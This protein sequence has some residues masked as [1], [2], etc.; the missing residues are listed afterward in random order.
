MT[1]GSDFSH[2]I[3]LLLILLI[4]LILLIFSQSFSK[5]ARD[6]GEC[7]VVQ[8]NHGS[9]RKY[10]PSTTGP[11]ARPL[12]HTAHSFVRSALLT[13]LA[14]CAVLICSKAGGKVSDSMSQNQAVLN[15]S[16]MEGKKRKSL[17]C[18][19]LPSSLTT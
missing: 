3:F 13:S 12:A 8:N 1:S 15:D 18:V 9:R 14:R 4:S 17:K 2:R 6:N 11:L 10:W 16:G 7:T 19:S 5:A